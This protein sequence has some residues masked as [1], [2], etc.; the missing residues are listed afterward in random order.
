MQVPQTED[1]Y[2]K[3]LRAFT[4]HEP[5]IRAFV[6]RLVPSRT[7]ADDVL[8]EVAIVLWERFDDFRE[9]GD[10]R[11]WACGIARFKALSRLRDLSRDRLVLST[12]VVEMIAANSLDS[13]PQLQRERHMLE[14]C[15]QK[16]SPKDQ[17]LL[18]KAYET[19]SQIRDV[20]ELSGRSVHGFYQW[21]YRMRQTL[22][23]CIRR[24]LARET[25][26]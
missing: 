4:T 1:R 10:F 14:L 26:S 7:D 3:F 8:Q 6:R 9:E 2:Q 23:D 18:A 20:A 15:F 19:G 13:E 17:E 11:S 5:A 21:L 12:D 24:E 22:L 25:L 16:V